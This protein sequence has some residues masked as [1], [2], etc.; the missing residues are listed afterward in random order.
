MHLLRSHKTRSLRYKFL[1]KVA[2][3]RLHIPITAL[4]Q[5]DPGDISSFRI[6]IQRIKRE[7]IMRPRFSAITRFR[8]SSNPKLPL[9]RN[10]VPDAWRGRRLGI[11]S[12]PFSRRARSNSSLRILYSLSP[13]T[14]HKRYRWWESTE[15]IQQLRHF[16]TLCFTRRIRTQLPNKEFYSPHR[17][18]RCPCFKDT[19]TQHRKLNLSRSLNNLTGVPRVSCFL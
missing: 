10:T 3:K 1:F 12:L 18:T 17:V 5:C 15:E 16:Y 6:S 11:L 2:W 9:I 19:P 4:V 13:S 14:R 8:L 7:S